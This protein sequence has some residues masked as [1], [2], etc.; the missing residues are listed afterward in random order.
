MN[1][2]WG[3]LPSL[4]MKSHKI[5]SSGA[6]SLPRSD[7]AQVHQDTA[8]EA[9]QG[10]RARRMRMLVQRGRQTGRRVPMRGRNQTRTAARQEK[11]GQYKVIKPL[12]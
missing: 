11:N 4:S 7:R 3:S 1:N 8:K 2:R 5:G 6:E 10:A 9:V 12:S